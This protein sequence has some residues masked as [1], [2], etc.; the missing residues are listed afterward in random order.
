MDDFELYK[1]RIPVAEIA[2]KRS[3]TREAVYQ[4]LRKNNE[5]TKLVE[6]R[7]LERQ[8]RAASSVAERLSE[9]ADLIN[10]GMSIKKVALV[11]NIQYNTLR[12]ALKGTAWDNSHTSKRGRNKKIVRA[13][14]NG[15]S[16]LK[17]ARRFGISQARVSKILSKWKNS[18]R[19]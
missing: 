17:V 3:V 13:L 11:L 18:K 8:Q 6:A 2:R 14:D 7:R 15:A 1:N 5:F 19:T 4:Q 9:A 12:E 10:D 16:Q